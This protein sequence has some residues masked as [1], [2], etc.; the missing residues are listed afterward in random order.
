MEMNLNRIIANGVEDALTKIEFELDGRIYSLHELGHLMA[1]GE[2]G[3]VIR[4]EKCRYYDESKESEGR[5]FCSLQKRYLMPQD[6]CSKGWRR[7]KYE[8]QNV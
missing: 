4:C 3:R 5:C 8:S 6:Y 2:I 7:I 1:L